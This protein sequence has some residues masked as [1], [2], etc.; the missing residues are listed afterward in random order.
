MRN[1]GGIEFDGRFW[2]ARPQHRRWVLRPKETDICDRSRLR[3][4]F[5]G[6]LR[7][8]LSCRVVP[9]FDG[10]G[11]VYKRLFQNAFADGPQHQAEHPSLE[12]LAFA[13]TTRSTSVVP[14]A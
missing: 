3:L 7:S 5:T 12:V 6:L 9:G 10:P 2:M 13:T 4:D 8:L 11:G 14:L 1:A